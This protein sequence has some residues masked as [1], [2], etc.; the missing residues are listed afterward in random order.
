[1]TDSSKI[2]WKIGGEAGFGII[3]TG[4][5]FSKIASRS[6]YHVFDY[7]EY[8][9][10]IRGGH[11]AYEVIVS[12]DPVITLKEEI[13]VLV[14]LNKQTY[15]KHNVRLSDRALVIFDNE[16]FEPEGKGV[17]IGVP[18]R[19]FLKEM[20]GEKVMLNA[21]A[22]GA[23]LALMRGDVE[24]L[25]SILERQFQKKGEKIV[26]FN[27]KFAKQGY[28]FVLN[29]YSQ[30]I[31][32]WLVR[33]EST[34]RQAVL[35]GN[36]AFAIASVAADCR[37]YCAYPMTPASSIL[38]TLALWQEKT[39]M[40]VRHAEDE[41][42]VINTALG[43]SF[44]GVRSSVGT[45]G[46]GFA[47]MVES[48]AYAGIAEIPIVIFISQR[49]GPATGMPTWT[50]QGDLLFA[51]HAGHG[52]FPKIVL[53]PA[54]AEEMLEFTL[55]A[56]DLADIYQ[57]P[58][59]I[60]A[61]MFLSESHK[62][63][64]IESILNLF[65]NYKPQRG[66]IIKEADETNYLR[67]RLTDDGISEMLIPGQKGIYYQ[68]NSYEHEEDG[69]TTEESISRKKQVE[70]RNKKHEGYLKTH[71]VPPSV[72]GQITN[73]DIVFVSWGSTKG[74]V[75]EAVFKLNDKGQRTASIHFTHVFPMDRK[76]ILS[77]MPKGKR[78]I[79]IE[80]NSHLQFGK[81]LRQETGIDIQEGITKYDG[82]PIFP[83][84]ILSHVT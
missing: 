70:K 67:Y 15:D 37:L 41:I 56:Y 71:F 76:E 60:L 68:A 55:K 13:D 44:A 11:N 46:G 51:V 74:S 66:K 61:D 42:S 20:Q 40:V 14:C 69:F 82:R 84:D 45:S 2:Q 63:I 53:A 4:L 39:G 9:S 73:A 50:E 21:I 54:D 62:S 59:I 78:Y 23:S 48:I 47:L 24:L 65:Q 18:F 25:Y 57:T 83:E 43:A 33:Q 64:K 32:S 38:T 10:L 22:L 16:E 75:N 29:N 36:D 17:K 26:D 1:M 81:L 28:G 6:G 80:N 35:T 3:T 52:E 31:Q 8:P 19:R 72:N 58:V 77:V 7:V 49:P 5:T 27:K 34:I 12:K 79:L 30:H